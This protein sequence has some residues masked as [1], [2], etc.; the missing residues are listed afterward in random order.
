MAFVDGESSFV[1]KVHQHHFLRF[2]A[3]AFACLLIVLAEFAI[4]CYAVNG[5]PIPHLEAKM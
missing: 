3:N 5:L 4:D 1:A 2:D